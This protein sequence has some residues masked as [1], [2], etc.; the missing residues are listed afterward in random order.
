MTQQTKVTSLHN[1][2]QKSYFAPYSSYFAPSKK[3][4]NFWVFFFVALQVPKVNVIYRVTI[5]EIRSVIDQRARIT[6]ERIN[7]IGMAWRGG[8]AERAHE[9]NNYKHV[10][11]I[12]VINGTN[13]SPVR[14]RQTTLK[15]Y[16]GA[17]KLLLIGSFS[18]ITVVVI[19]ELNQVDSGL[20]SYGHVAK[21]Q[22]GGVPPWRL[23]S[24]SS[25]YKENASKDW[26]FK[27]GN[28]Y[29]EIYLSA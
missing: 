21:N 28:W 29:R 2:S 8:H 11:K 14:Q 26:P 23:Q 15:L 13:S 27:V 12:V 22:D 17:K 20:N 18:G 19:V 1:R 3:L 5:S 16:N 6:I 25:S 7:N 24:T 10:I 4:V 9:T